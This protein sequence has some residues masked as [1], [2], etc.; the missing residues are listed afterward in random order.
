MSKLKL[1]KLL[2]ESEGL[3][4]GEKFGLE[5]VGEQ[6]VQHHKR[7]ND[8]L[9]KYMAG[10]KKYASNH[11]KNPELYKKLSDLYTHIKGN[12][13]Y[14]TKQAAN[15]YL[16]KFEKQYKS[17]VSEGKVPY[18]QIGTNKND[19]YILHGKDIPVEEYRIRGNADNLVIRKG[20][21]KKGMMVW[22][23]DGKG[24]AKKLKVKYT[25]DSKDGKEEH[26]IT[27]KGTFTPKDVVGY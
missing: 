11:R 13:Y 22:F 15:K 3:S 5:E 16:S 1:N 10:V 27:N 24:S 6:I 12:Y 2:K 20:D 26:Y 23:E 21:I 8:M 14:T 19:G 4:R 25:M 17:L 9:F 18:K 7:L